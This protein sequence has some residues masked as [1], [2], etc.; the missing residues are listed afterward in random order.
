MFQ[1]F[2]LPDVLRGRLKVV[3]CGTRPGNESARRQAYYAGPGTKFWP[4][5]HKVGLT[6]RRLKPAEYPAVTRMGIGLTD[7]V[8]V[9]FGNDE[10]ITERAWDTFSLE[11]KLRRYRPRVIAF[12]GKTA[13]SKA[14]GI[15]TAKLRYGRQEA[16]LVRSVVY[17]LPSTSGRAGSFWDIRHWR[18]LAREVRDL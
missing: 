16:P 11:L 3:F 4:T 7:I 10:G 5:L 15:P 12:N 13:A 18:A 14:L 17:V 2:V 9:T 6:P 1:K 8:K